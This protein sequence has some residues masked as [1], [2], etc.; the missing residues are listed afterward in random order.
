MLE[1]CSS[2]KGHLNAGEHCSSIGGDLTTVVALE[3][4]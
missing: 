3:G 2:T 1:Y 4:A